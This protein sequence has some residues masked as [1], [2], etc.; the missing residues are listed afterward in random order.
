MKYLFLHKRRGYRM[1]PVL[2]LLE[3]QT[4][5]PFAWIGS[6]NKEHKVPPFYYIQNITII[7]IYFKDMALF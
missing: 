7:I 4:F 3:I 2:L 1:I 5:M 6:V